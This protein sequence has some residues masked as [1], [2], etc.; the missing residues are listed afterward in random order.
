MPASP[1]ATKPRQQPRNELQRQSILEAT[2]RLFIDKGFG[3]T[4]INDIAD[5]LGVTRTAVYYYFQSKEAILEAL[6]EE[7][8]ERAGQL[9]RGVQG[10]QKLPPQ[11]ALRQLV[12][13]HATLILTH[14]VQ[15]RVVERSESS[16]PESGRVAARASRHAVLDQFEQT[17]QQGI[18]AGVFQVP[19]ARVAAFAIIGLCNW[20]A[21][22]YEPA[23]APVESVAEMLTELALRSVLRG[24][25]RHRKPASVT[26]ALGLLR[27][28]LDALETLARRR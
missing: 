22:W 28:N 12:L 8:T 1:P 23:E 15:F 21:W 11:E 17:I 25:D 10:R 5:A 6:T 20:S 24:D 2:S 26:E 27:E 16:L 9:A 4:N 7:V 13:Q 18:A 3:G 14:P 19:D